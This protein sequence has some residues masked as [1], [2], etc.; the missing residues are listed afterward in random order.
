MLNIPELPLP[1]DARHKISQSSFAY[2]VA[3][4]VLSG[5]QE[6]PQLLHSEEQGLPLI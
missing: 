4:G 1:T 5:S 3:Y 6:L 2:L